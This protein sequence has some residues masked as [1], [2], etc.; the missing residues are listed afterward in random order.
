MKIKKAVI[1]VAGFGTRFMPITKSIPKE[2]LPIIDTPALEYIV[3][4]AVESGITDIIFIVNA[5]K[6]SIVDYFDQNFELEY[7]LKKSNKEYEL[8]QITNLTKLANMYFVRQK[9]MLG[10]AGAIYYAKTFVA[11]E[12]FVVLNG[13]DVFIGEKPALKSLIDV[14]AQTGEMVVAALDV[15]RNAV[16]QYGIAH[17]KEDGTLSAIVEKP[18]IDKAPSNNAIIGRYLLLPAI[19]D[20]IEK[21]APS[22]NNELYL[23][24]AIN[25]MIADGYKVH[26]SII[27]NRY[28]DLG[29]KVEYV[30]AIIDESLN[31]EDTR[32]PILTYLKDVIK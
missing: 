21:I 26:T 10:T 27:D 5:Y 31:R 1:P 25:D 17:Y 6:N 24:D 4:E 2:M 16:N 12:P 14:H 22:Q 3:R 18:S 13:D 29:N 30:K 23:T 32:E 11:D 7:L 28:Y 8:L 20:Y 9:E 15:D 19:F